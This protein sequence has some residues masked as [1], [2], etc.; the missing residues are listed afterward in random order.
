MSAITLQDLLLG[1]SDAT[2]QALFTRSTCLIFNQGSLGGLS[3]VPVTRHLFPESCGCS[4]RIECDTGQRG[5]GRVGK[6]G[7]RE[8]REGEGEKTETEHTWVFL[9]FYNN[10]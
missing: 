9:S 2:M 1:V 4:Y 5:V 8:T 3:A 7:R 6:A 10:G